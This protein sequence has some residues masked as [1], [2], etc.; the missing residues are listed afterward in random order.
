MGNESPYRIR[1]RE[2]IEGALGEIIGTL[3]LAVL[4]IASGVTI[5]WTPT[6]IVFS[7]IA[8]ILFV[9]Y[10]VDPSLQRFVKLRIATI[11]RAI[12]S[13]TDVLPKWNIIANNALS[14]VA[15][16][17]NVDKHFL[18]ISHRR[19]IRQD[20]Q[21]YLEMV[22][23]WLGGFKW[24]LLLD[25]NG[26]VVDQYGGWPA[27]V[28]ECPRCHSPTLRRFI[29]DDKGKVSYIEPYIRCRR[30][31]QRIVL[32]DKTEATSPK[33]LPDTNVILKEVREPIVKVTAD[34][35]TVK[36]E[37]VIE[38][39][40]QAGKICPYVEFQVL[41]LRKGVH[42]GPQKIRSK[43]SWVVE[44]DALSTYTLSAEWTFP[45]SIVP[46]VKPPHKVKVELYPYPEVKT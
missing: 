3:V 43:E 46:L 17:N 28:E 11:K 21:E 34:G 45:I 36:I 27:I 44:V 29:Q 42:S 32:A 13:E 20:N 39:K 31:G 37:F 19:L 22:L 26:N 33:V 6:L 18:S 7:L 14:D 38:N 10:K 9:W 5:G 2:V 35:V 23:E 24:Y 30:C 41:D 12:S 40:G 15:R 1:L 8:V 4:G 25:S 16:E